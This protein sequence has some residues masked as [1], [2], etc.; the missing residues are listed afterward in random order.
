MTLNRPNNARDLGRLA[1]AC[2]LDEDFGPGSFR[3][4]LDVRAA[5]LIGLIERQWD[6]RPIEATPCGLNV[7]C[8]GLYYHYL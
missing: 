6:H 3:P 5:G 8:T 1:D 4:I 7:Y 2:E